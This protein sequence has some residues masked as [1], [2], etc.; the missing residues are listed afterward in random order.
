MYAPTIA[1]TAATAA[2]SVQLSATKSVTYSGL[3]AFAI[4]PRLVPDREPVPHRFRRDVL[5]IAAD[6]AAGVKHLARHRISN[7]EAG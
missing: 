6:L 2:D 1:S 3:A 4:E 7:L 5:T